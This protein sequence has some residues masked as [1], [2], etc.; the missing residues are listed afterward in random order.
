M[1][2]RNARLWPSPSIAAALDVRIAAGRVVECEPGLRPVAG[3]EEINAAGCALLP[4]LH[5]H[6]VHLRA[7]AAARVSVQVGPGAAGPVAGRPRS[8]ADSRGG[9]RPRLGQR[10]GRFPRCDRLHRR[11]P[12][13]DRS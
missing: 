6:H 7:L 9:R 5:D 10:T 1:L 13:R 12:G 11:H 8:R 2:I 3:E 4:G